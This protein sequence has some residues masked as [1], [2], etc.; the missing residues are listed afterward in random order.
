MGD[1]QGALPPL[2][3]ALQPPV[4]DDDRI[5]AQARFELARVLVERDPA[6]A[7][8]LAAKA[9]DTFRADTKTPL[10]ARDAAAAEAWLAKAG[11]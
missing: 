11:R 1:A 5:V 7:R 8:T 10:R 2:E 9:R 3:R 6:R 4:S